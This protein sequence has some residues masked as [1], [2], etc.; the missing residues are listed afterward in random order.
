MARERE[1]RGLC[2][3]N[4]SS[5]FSCDRAEKEKARTF[6]CKPK[7]KTQETVFFF[8][9]GKTPL[10]SVGFIGKFNLITFIK[11]NYPFFFTKVRKGTSFSYT[12]CKLSHSVIGIKTYTTVCKLSHF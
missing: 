6:C 4:P 11:K 7:Q 3:V 10:W 12:C 8:F 2:V 9:L 5:F 1:G